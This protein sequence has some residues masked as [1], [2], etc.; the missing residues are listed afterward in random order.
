VDTENA[1][2]AFLAAETTRFQYTEGVRDV[3]KISPDSYTFD[4]LTLDR[5]GNDSVQLSLF[6]DYASNLAVYPEWHAY[7]RKYQPPMLIVWGKND[8]FFTVDG[9]KAFLSDLPHAGLHL[10]DTGHFALEDHADFIAGEIE[11]FLQQASATTA[12]ERETA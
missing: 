8:P 7:F 3:T 5:P 11:R 4:Q 2:R 10:L 1:V 9:A 6:R 12:Q